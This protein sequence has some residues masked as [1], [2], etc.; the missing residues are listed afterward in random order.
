M[1]VV[2][3]NTMRACAVVL[4]AGA[5]MVEQVATAAAARKKLGLNTRKRAAP[6][7]PARRVQQKQRLPGNAQRT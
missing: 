5:G 2:N 1:G 3:G 7:P 4:C 6:A